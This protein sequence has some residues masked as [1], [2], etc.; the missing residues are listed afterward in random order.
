[1]EF[2]RYAV[3]YAPPP[4]QLADFGAAWLGWDMTRGAPVAHPDF[5][6]LPMPVEE[7]TATP[8]KYGFHATLKP[9]FR[10]AEGRSE[11]E[12]VEAVG[13]LGSR[14]FHPVMDLQLSVTQ[15]GRFLALTATGNTAQLGGLAAM[16]V[17]RLDIFRAPAGEAELA[18][19]RGAGLSPGQE[20]MLM[21]WG[22][23][24][25]MEEFRFHMTL[26]GKLP[27]TVL[28]ELHSVLD[29]ALE[30]VI[31]GPFTLDTICLVGEDD[32]GRFHLMH[33]HTLS[34]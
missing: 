2:K 3:Y 10:L 8:R 23:P 28:P 14:T 24:Y 5:P 11:A 15:L 16:C 1:M 29:K 6:G 25:V 34:A 27:K 12:L 18:R 17:E 4:G 21:R 19:R 26:T 31:R 20:A 30:G 13:I 32:E 9:P 22:Y 7:I 33:R